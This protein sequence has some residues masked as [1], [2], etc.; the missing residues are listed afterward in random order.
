MVRVNQIPHILSADINLFG[1]IFS[2]SIPFKQG[3]NILSGENGTGKTH[4]LREIK[5]GKFQSP[6]GT[7]PRV[8]A[9][10]PK[11]NSDR[12]KLETIFQEIRQQNRALP[13]YVQQ[14]MKTEL[15]DST[16][17]NY[18]SFAEVYVYVYEEQCKDGGIQTDKMKKVTSDFNSIIQKIFLNYKLVSRWDAGRGAPDIKLKKEGQEI[19]IDSLSL[20]EQEV[21]SLVFNLYTAR[22]T[23][24]VFLVDEPEIHLNWH[25]EESLF[26]FF[27]WFCSKFDK[28][29]IVAT[30][31]RVVFKA[32]FFGK[33]PISSLG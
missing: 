32:P 33:N 19:A 7:S 17:D 24:D 9:F 2:E 12:K 31:S 11:R 21:L 4:V 3:L 29:V 8:I 16:F 30:H 20:G 25:L 23:N 14:R 13:T 1:G 27:D 18:A 28:Q 6:E 10:N 15:Q 26:R 22:N 5:K